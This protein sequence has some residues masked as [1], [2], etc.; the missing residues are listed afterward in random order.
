MQPIKTIMCFFGA[1]HFRL[2]A[3]AMLAAL[4]AGCAAPQEKITWN[5]P[6]EAAAA[7][8]VSA[9]PP[10]GD[11]A[12]DRTLHDKAPRDASNKTAGGPCREFQESIV[13][14]GKPQRAYGTACRQPDGTWKRV[15][16]SKEPT[17]EAPVSSFPYRGHPG[18][19]ARYPHYYPRYHFGFGYGHRRSHFGYGVHW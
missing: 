16:S 1:S 19:Y 13:I 14:D 10:P 6:R 8:P 12:T 5:T 4:L 3:T 9:K 7:P 18:G 15:S 2:A 17:T 11:S